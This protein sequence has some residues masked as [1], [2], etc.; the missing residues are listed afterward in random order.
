MPRLLFVLLVFG[1]FLTLAPVQAQEMVEDD[2]FNVLSDNLNGQQ[3]EVTNAP[4]AIRVATEPELGASQIA[5]PSP[6]QANQA[7]QPY[8][9]GRDEMSGILAAGAVILATVIIVL[10]FA[11]ATTWGHSKKES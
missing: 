8:V 10:L 11:L 2:F 4:A 5:K 9:A 1:C 6:T 3:M 7:S